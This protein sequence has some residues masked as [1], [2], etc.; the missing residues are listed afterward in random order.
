ME[1]KFY[2]GGL[3]IGIAVLTV[4]IIIIA[5]FVITVNMA[6]KRGRSALGWFLTALFTSPFL[7]MFFLVLLGET[8]QKRIDRI[9][10]EEELKNRF[11]SNSERGVIKCSEC[12]EMIMKEAL[13]CKHC[14]HKKENVIDTSAKIDSFGEWKKNNPSG[15]L[16]DYYKF[17]N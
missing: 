11:L 13:V 2:W 14:G 9:I 12:A 10:E 8:N 16:N 3:F 17:L 15:G 7:A 4:S 6:N 5:L 1:T